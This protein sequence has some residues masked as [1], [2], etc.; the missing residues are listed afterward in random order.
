MIQSK[1][2]YRKTVCV[3]VAAER[4]INDAVIKQRYKT[5]CNI[6]GYSR[7][8]QPIS[9]RR[10]STDDFD[11]SIFAHL[12]GE[13]IGS[14]LLYSEEEPR[15]AMLHYTEIAL[16]HREIPGEN[17]LCI[18]ISGC[19]NQCVNCHYP[20]LQQA[21]CGD[22]LSES[23]QNIVELYIR[24]ASCVCF[25]GEG[26][27]GYSEQRELTKYALYARSKGLK[28]CLYSGRDSVL[29]PWME[30]F[31]YV[32]LGSYQEEYG[33]LDSPATNQRMYRRE[34]SNFVDMTSVFWNGQNG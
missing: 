6:R 2:Q 8:L 25:M 22:L 18:Y 19:P 3:P 9:F 13:Q 29:E 10:F 11:Q 12:T 23:Y 21:D 30:I 4:S 17:S 20:E 7:L 1:Y 5:C 28:T 33:A 27:G 31:D 16:S 24:Q 15:K 34:G 32:K 26:A 14:R